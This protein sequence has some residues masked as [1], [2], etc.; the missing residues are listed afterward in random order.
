MPAKKATAPEDTE[1]NEIEA[2]ETA[3]AELLIQAKQLADLGFSQ[4]ALFEST[5]AMIEP[6]NPALVEK[7]KELFATLLVSRQK[8]AVAIQ[9]IA[10]DD[11]PE[12]SGDF[13]ELLDEFLLCANRANQ[14][15]REIFPTRVVN[16]Q[17]QGGG[18]KKMRRVSFEIGNETFEIKASRKIA[19]KKEGVV[20][21]AEIE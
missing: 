2:A 20:V 1:I 10:K 11:R 16:S 14:I 12:D 15:G 17:G 5:I 3:A 6:I 13:M 8:A 9:M 4:P 18:Q 19:G 7:A 21:N